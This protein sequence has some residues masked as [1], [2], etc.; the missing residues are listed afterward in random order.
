M[1]CQR[2]SPGSLMEKI[3]SKATEVIEQLSEIGYYGQHDD[4]GQKASTQDAGEYMAP[5]AD[6]KLPD[7]SKGDS[8]DRQTKKK[9]NK[10]DGSEK[11]V[12]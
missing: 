12:Q 5:F 6:L 8:K 11:K 10:S 3:M 7:N 9:D 4:Y 2:F 1:K